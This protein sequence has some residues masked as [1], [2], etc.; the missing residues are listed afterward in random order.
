M[1]QVCCGLII[2]FFY[3]LNIEANC[4]S[5]IWRVEW[6]HHYFIMLSCLQRQQRSMR[7]GYLFS[8]LSLWSGGEPVDRTWSVLNFVFSRKL[9]QNVLD[10]IP[11]VVYL[12]LLDQWKESQDGSRRRQ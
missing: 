11:T 9:F 8:S 10:L 5:F 4:I 2:S 12:S 6:F 1:Q 3:S 7:P